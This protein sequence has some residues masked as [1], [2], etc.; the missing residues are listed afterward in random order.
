MKRLLLLVPVLLLFSCVKSEEK[1][2]SYMPEKSD[3]YPINV[4]L[5]RPQV[6]NVSKSSYPSAAVDL[7]TD[8]NIYIYYK[9]R[10]LREYSGYYDDLSSIMISFP[11]GKDEFNIYMLGNVGRYDLPQDERKIEQSM[12]V[13]GSYGQFASCGVPVVGIFR[14]YI[15][16]SFSDF[17]LQ[18]LVGQFN[19]RMKESADEADYRI[20]DVRVMNCAMDV[21]P[22]SDDSKASIFSRSYHYADKSS[23]DMLNETDVENLNDGLPVTL[24]FVENLQGVLLPENTDKKA[25]IPSSLSSSIAD[26]CTYIEI[27]ADVTTQIAK[28][29]DCRYRFYPGADET[30]D[31]SIR[32][33]TLYDITL[34]FTQNMVCEEEWRIEA[35]VP[36][37]VDVWLNKQEA[38]VIKGAEDM[39]FVRGLDNDGGLM[40]F[41]VSVL[42]SSGY[43]NVQKQ[44]VTYNG[45][46]HLGLKFTSNVPLSGLYPIGV[47][48]TYLTEV[49]RISSRE[50]Y[51]GKPLYS[52]DIPVRVYSKLF[53]LHVSLERRSGEAPYSIAL[54][55]RNPM[56]LGMSVSSNYVCDGNTF[57]TDQEYAYNFEYDDGD[58]VESSMNAVGLSPVYLGELSPD[59]TYK[60]LTSINLVIRNVV[61]DVDEDAET[62]LSYPKFQES[63]FLFTGENTNAY[64]GPNPG[65]Y[66]AFG[67]AYPDDLICDFN[68]EYD[69]VKY[70][71]P[72]NVG[73]G[74]KV[75]TEGLLPVCICSKNARYF[76]SGYVHCNLPE[77]VTG[78]FQVPF[79]QE[80]EGKYSKFPFYI[81][82][83]S[84]SCT[85]SVL[86]SGGSI[87]NWNNKTTRGVT[88]EFLGPGR[89]L[90]SETR[91]YAYDQ[92]RTHK[93]EFLIQ[94]WKN[95]F[96]TVKTQCSADRYVGSSFLTINGASAW[97]GGDTSESGVAA[98]AI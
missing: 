87:G 16:G 40:D 65:L 88:M 89:D 92:N 70:S 78:V 31:F 66:P 41:D 57:T 75:V 79:L 28:Y 73:T 5:G 10:L 9:G 80:D 20:K 37:V 17:P 93:M 71:K 72:I 49:V 60:N 63:V 86:V 12:Y 19:I 36:E 13:V 45:K 1:L 98:D 84:M 11:S 8:L 81:A 85:N 30:T 42:S 55:G 33:N 95:L 68:F 24:Y 50:T 96:G 77:E 82:N 29:T 64:F 48:P 47:E 4:Y 54:R 15:R 61:S 90:F 67:K 38:M 46:R 56:G 44:I 58:G 39:I 43:I 97:V 27:T 83:G 51:N 62:V 21:Y 52:K 23:G 69:G 35:P 25:K 22:F 91:T 26:M 14:N 3:K 53:P 94:I 32:R 2:V 76:Y 7:L 34:D 18:R 59:V 74:V 6:M